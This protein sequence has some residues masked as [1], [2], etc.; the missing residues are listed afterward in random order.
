MQYL[1][2]TADRRADVRQVLP[3]ARSVVALGTVYN[4]D[5]PYSTERADPG[6]AR[7]ARYAWG[8]DYHDVIGRRLMAARMRTVG[9][10]GR[11][12][13]TPARPGEGLT[14]AGWPRGSART[15]ASSTRRIVAL[16]VSSSAASAW[17]RP[18]VLTSA[19]ISPMPSVRPALS[20]VPARRAAVPVVSDD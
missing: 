5:R 13:W 14:P 15:R 6:E 10:D 3:S 17:N 12:Q 7:I 20:T 19:E 11:G 1:A 2:R 9:R 8:D 4:T 16:L 18:P